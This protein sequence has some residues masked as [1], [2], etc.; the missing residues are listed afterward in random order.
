M[1]LGY[2]R[3]RITAAILAGV[4][5]A[6]LLLLGNGPSDLN[7]EQAAKKLLALLGDSDAASGTIGNDAKNG[8]ETPLLP[9]SDSAKQLSNDTRTTPEF[10]VPTRG[11]GRPRKFQEPA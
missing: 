10:S 1:L 9:A 4:D 6:L 2:L 3:R 5:D 11:P 8:K 7:D